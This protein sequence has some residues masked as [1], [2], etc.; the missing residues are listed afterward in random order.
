MS[1]P[2]SPQET[3]LWSASHS[4]T[5]DISSTDH[6]LGRPSRAIYIGGDGDGILVV[7]LT[8]DSANVTFSGLTAGTLLP[9]RV[10]TVV[11][12]GTGVTDIVAL[13]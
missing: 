10:K 7:R 6:T 5:I 4:T 9:I 13:H 1:E 11:R 8:G 3:E 2:S 12:T